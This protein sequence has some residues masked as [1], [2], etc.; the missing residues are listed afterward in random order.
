[1][2]TTA[3]RLHDRPEGKDFEDFIA[4]YFQCGGFY[5]ERNIEEI[6]IDQIL[7]ALQKVSAVTLSKLCNNKIHG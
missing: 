2:S 6:D 1:M 4:A 3:I 7:I 5:V